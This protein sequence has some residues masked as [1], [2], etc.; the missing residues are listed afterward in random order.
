MAQQAMTVRLDSQMKTQFDSLCEQFGMS[1]NTA[2]NIFV[3]AVVRT[4]SI[5]FSI[6]ISGKKDIV[7]ENA[8]K[9]I[10]SMQKSAEESGASEM[11]LEEINE[12]IRLA[13]EERKKRLLTEVM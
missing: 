10:E 12:E 11:T 6:G 1:A 8:I 13:R 9:A 4:Q 5:P 3:N 7:R 2:I